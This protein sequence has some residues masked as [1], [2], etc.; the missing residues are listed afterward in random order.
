M[1]TPEIH[2]HPSVGGQAADLGISRVL[3]AVRAEF[4]VPDHFPA[5]VVA[6]AE[7][8][9]RTGGAPPPG[10]STEREDARA[11][12]LVTIDPE[13]SRDLDQAYLGERR[14][15]GGFRI[16][17]AIADVAWFVAPGGAV[18]REANERGVTL[19]QP[20]RR[21]ALHPEVLS[22][23]AASLLA[24]QDRPALLWS[25]DLDVDA[26]PTGAVAFRR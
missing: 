12:E 9:A 2:L 26:M 14:T 19:Y 15:G 10:A 13:G 6:E 3:D 8:S 11:L 23:G 25:I 18:D 7:A 21:T 22:Q 1:P 4:H 16:H 17:Y 5:D 24:D 20:D